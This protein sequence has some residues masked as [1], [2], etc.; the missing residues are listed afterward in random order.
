[1]KF[2]IISLI[3][4]VTLISVSFADV[5][6]SPPAPDVLIHME[7]DGTAETSIVT[8]TYY[9]MGSTNA[10]AQG[11]VSQRVS[12]FACTNGTCTPNG[13]FYKFNPCYDFPSGYFSY[14]YN[15]INVSS[16]SFSNSEKHGK[17]E[18]TIDAPSGKIT[19][20]DSSDPLVWTCGSSIFAILL[21]ISVLAIRQEKS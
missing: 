17:Y 9:C 1:M 12:E 14:D 11:A 15:G 20:S 4:L 10:S 5:G 8:L 21:V 19:K 6:P 13:W 18:M 7:K 16:A 2:T 3:L